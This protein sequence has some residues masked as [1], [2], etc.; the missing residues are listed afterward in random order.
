MKGDQEAAYRRFLV[1][2]KWTVADSH[3][4]LLEIRE[5]RSKFQVDAFLV[6]AAMTCGICAPRFTSNRTVIVRGASC[7]SCGHS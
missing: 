4:L 5:W 6:R 2:R 3:K 1:A 7:A